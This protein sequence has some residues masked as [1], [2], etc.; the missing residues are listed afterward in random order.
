MKDTDK[1]VAAIF[2]ASVCG[3]VNA[4]QDTYLDTY[5]QF[6]DKMEKR[7]KKPPID[8]SKAAASLKRQPKRR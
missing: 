3:H 1:I 2:A 8:W 4:D 7:A 5:E 6:L